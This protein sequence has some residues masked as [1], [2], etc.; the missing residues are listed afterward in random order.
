M[1]G[2][3]SHTFC[4]GKGLASRCFAHYGKDSCSARKLATPRSE[5]SSNEADSSLWN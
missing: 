4:F 2:I 1:P 3:W 5:L